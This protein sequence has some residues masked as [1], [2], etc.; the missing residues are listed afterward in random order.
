MVKDAEIAAVRRGVHC[1]CD[2]EPKVQ[3]LCVGEEVGGG[4]GVDA[5]PA[6]VPVQEGVGAVQEGEGR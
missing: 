5:G 6:V 2:P 1:L 4:G 3:A